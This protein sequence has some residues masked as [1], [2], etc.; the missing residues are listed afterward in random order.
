MLANIDIVDHLLEDMRVPLGSDFDLY[1]NHVYRMINLTDHFYPLQDENLQ[2]VAI[3]AVFHD[4]GIWLD[5]TFDYLE[6]SAL[7]AQEYVRSN[8]H[9]EWSTLI[10][11]MIMNHHR[12]R[13]VRSNKLVE[14]FRRADW[15]DVT[16]GTIG[17]GVP[18]DLMQALTGLYPLLGFQKRLAMLTFHQL[19]KHPLNPLPMMRW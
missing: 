10:G 6:P 15:A 8:G 2:Q 7:R 17:F 14:A 12:I 16:Y 11:A 5:R 3:A 18:A 1:R 9:G 19:K 4:A 13:P